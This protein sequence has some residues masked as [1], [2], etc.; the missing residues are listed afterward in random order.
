MS[1]RTK[2]FGYIRTRKYFARVIDA[3][4]YNKMLGVLDNFSFDITIHDNPNSKKNDKIIQFKNPRCKGS[5]SK[6]LRPYGLVISEDYSKLEQAVRETT[7]KMTRTKSNN[8]NN[9]NKPLPIQIQPG[10]EP[11]TDPQ[12]NDQEEKSN[13]TLNDQ[14]LQ[15][16][17]KLNNSEKNT[18]KM[19]DMLQRLTEEITDL[20]KELNFYKGLNNLQV[21]E[22][23][24]IDREVLTVKEETIVGVV[25]NDVKVEC[26]SDGEESFE[27]INNKKIHI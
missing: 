4:N 1:K 12:I 10:T 25:Y 5:L 23:S 8:T 13:Q 27:I 15:I 26:E 18:E 3:E 19:L 16:N 22:E 9:K 11:S 21:A 7:R 6:V 17:K 24:T 2:A 14:L 20:K